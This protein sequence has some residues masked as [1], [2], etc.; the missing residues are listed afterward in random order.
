MDRRGSHTLGLRVRV[1]VFSCGER[2]IVE[3]KES[4]KFR[5]RVESRCRFW[6]TDRDEFRKRGEI[7]G[8]GEFR[9]RGEFK[10]KG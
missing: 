10:G 1:K 9:G 2:D 7:R 6:I 8:S 5:D 4:S 3:F